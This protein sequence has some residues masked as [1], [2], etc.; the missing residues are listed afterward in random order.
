[1]RR[2]IFTVDAHIVDTNGTFHY[3]TG[4]PKNFDSKNYD[5]DINK[6]RIRALGDAAETFGAMC[7]I[8]TRQLQV[9]SVTTVTGFVEDSRIIGVLADLPDPDPEPE[10]EPETDG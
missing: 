10:P 9:V 6:A 7:K 3:I 4:Y 8:D 5:G 1:M 2:E